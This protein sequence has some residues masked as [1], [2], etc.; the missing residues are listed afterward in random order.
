[1]GQESRIIIT[2]DEFFKSSLKWIDS[3]QNIIQNRIVA[4]ENDINE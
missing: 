3:I 1:M 2:L 4:K